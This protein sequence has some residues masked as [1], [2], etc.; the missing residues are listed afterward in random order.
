MATKNLWGELP[1]VDAKSTPIKILREQ[2][3][4]LDEISGGLLR[5]TVGATAHGSKMQLVLYITV[6]TLNYYQF[7]LLRV[8]HDA[9]DVYPV[10][11]RTG[12]NDEL[13]EA[14]NEAEFVQILEN[15]LK[16]DRTREILQSLMA[17][18]KAIEG[19]TP[20]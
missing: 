13:G 4:V 3:S 5:G 10:Q 11:V 14:K 6:P 19:V 2:A 12:T 15:Q 1:R 7:G 17:Q 20:E 8:L 16:A 9:V 18:A